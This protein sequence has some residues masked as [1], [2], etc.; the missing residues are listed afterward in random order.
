MQWKMLWCTSMPAIILSHLCQHEGEEK[1]LE[2]QLSMKVSE[3]DSL[4]VEHDEEVRALQQQKEQVISQL[5]DTEERFQ[6]LLSAHEKQVK[7]QG[8]DMPRMLSLHVHNSQSFV[9]F[10]VPIQLKITYYACHTCRVHII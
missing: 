1:H 5:E 7:Q 10:K 3:Y 4:Y 6:H 9:L 8:I 2:E